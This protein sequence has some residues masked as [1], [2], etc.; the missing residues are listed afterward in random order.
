M[1]SSGVFGIF[2]HGSCSKGILY[3]CFKAKLVM[4][5]YVASSSFAHFRWLIVI[6]SG[7]SS[8]GWLLSWGVI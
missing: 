6:I 4:A 7:L 8:W 1:V 5:V 2:N 3:F